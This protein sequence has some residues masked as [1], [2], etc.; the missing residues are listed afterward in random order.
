MMAAFSIASL[1]ETSVVAPTRVAQKSPTA[2]AAYPAISDR[3]TAI[4]PTLSGEF[5]FDRL[6]RE[7]RRLFHL[8]FVFALKNEDRGGR[9]ARE[10]E[11]ERRAIARELVE[12]FGHFAPSSFSNSAS[13]WNAR[14][15]AAES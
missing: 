10:L 14:F 4:L 6:E 5:V 1:V 8:F 13:I 3:F 11:A 2:T 15:A 9:V 12:Q 7:F